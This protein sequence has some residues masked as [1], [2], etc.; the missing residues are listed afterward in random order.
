MIFKGNPV[1]LH[2]LKKSYEGDPLS[3][4]EGEAACGEHLLTP[5]LY[6]S[7]SKRESLVNLQRAIAFFMDASAGRS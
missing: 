6:F 4:P 3:L 2:S 5:S 7:R 1:T